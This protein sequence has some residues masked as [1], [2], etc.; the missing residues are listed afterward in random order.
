M[1]T[2]KT[3]TFKGVVG[4]VI[5]AAALFSTVGAAQLIDVDQ[6]D[7]ALPCP[8]I[9]GA[10]A[11]SDCAHFNTV[12]RKYA[13]SAQGAL[14]CVGYVDNVQADLQAS[15]AYLTAVDLNGAD[16]LTEAEEEMQ[17][18]KKISATQ[19]QIAGSLK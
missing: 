4:I 12:V 10:L 9:A 14:N 18:L 6:L 11:V 1:T 15:T 2:E 3:G 19:D 7:L 13:S 5:T 17:A 8:T 16:A